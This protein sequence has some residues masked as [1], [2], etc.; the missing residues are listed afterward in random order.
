MSSF[1]TPGAGPAQTPQELVSTVA[2]QKKEL[3][4]LRSQVELLHKENADLRASVDQRTARDKATIVQDALTSFKQL[5]DN[6]FIT[7]KE[8]NDRRQQLLDKL[9][10]TEENDDVS[11]RPDYDPLFLPEEIR[12]GGH[13]MYLTIQ[14]KNLARYPFGKPYSKP[15]L[16][17]LVEDKAKIPANIDVT[18]IHLVEIAH[19]NEPRLLGFSRYFFI[20]VDKKTHEVLNVYR[21]DQ[22]KRWI[23]QTFLTVDFGRYESKYFMF[24]MEIDKARAIQ[25]LLL[26]YIELAVANKSKSGD[27]D[28]DL[29][30]DNA[31]NGNSATPTKSKPPSG[32]FDAFWS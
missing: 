18:P 9:A 17:A 20:V 4:L 15:L 7:E 2:N 16:D 19:E 14:R 13:T 6:G 27:K 8:F 22:M 21:Y 32:W 28:A 29:F 12:L 1:S 30:E 3:V 26:K 25:K 23:F 11:K 31:D 5:K 10:E 24:R